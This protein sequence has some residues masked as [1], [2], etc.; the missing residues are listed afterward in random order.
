[1]NRIGVGE[2][3]GIVVDSDELA[4]GV[5]IVDANGLAN[6]ARF[7][8][9]L[10]AEAKGSGG[11]AYRV[12][13][14]FGEEDALDVT[15]RCTCPAAASRDFC[16]HATALLVAWARSPEAFAEGDEAPGAAR[17]RVRRGKATPQDLM[18]QGVEQ[19]VAL[20]RDLAVT[21][22]AAMGRDRVPVIEALGESLRTYK[23]R[24]LGARTLDLAK[25]LAEGVAQRGSM[26][27]IA[28][29]E[30]YCD[31]FLTA[32]K[33]EKHLAGG[34]P[35]DD[36]HVEE[37]VGKTWQKADRAPIA[38]LDLVEYAYLVK[39]TSDEFVIR[40]SR[41][42]DLVS[43]AHFSE[44]QIVP[45]F[46]TRRTDAK[47]SRA[48]AVRGG[49]RGSTY[50]GYPPTRLE[51]LDL[52]DP[53][54]I[55]HVALTPLVDVALTDVSAALVA[56]AEHRRDVF[57]PE[58]LP[59][60]VRVDTL[61]ARRGRLQAVDASGH[62]LHLP[63]D[64][65]LE[66][67][68]GDKLAGARLAALL[69]DVGVDAALPTLWPLAA[70]VERSAGYEL[71]TVFGQ[72]E[73]VRRVTLASGPTLGSAAWAETARAAGASDVTIALAEV[74]EALADAFA[75]GLVTL[76]PKVA[77]P[78]A[79]RL[80]DLGLEKQAELL[81]SI[82]ERGT[83]ARL[84]DFV[85]LFHVLGI[86]LVRLA[87]AA[88]V[89]RA[90]LVQVPTFESVFV[91]RPDRWLSPAEI[92]AA[93]AKGALDRYEAAVQAAHHYD[94]VPIE[95][96]STRIFPTWADG[97][98][99][100]YVARAFAKQPVEGIRAAKEAL[101]GPYGRVARMTGMRVLATVGGDEAR[102]ILD[103]LA[104][105]DPD[106][107]LRALAGLALD[108]LDR[109]TLGTEAVYRRRSPGRERVA[110]A[111]RDLASASTKD[112]RLAAVRLLAEIGDPSAV[113]ALRRAFTSDAAQEVRRDAAL[114]LALFVDTETVPV[115]VGQLARWRDSERD[116]KVAAAA[117]GKLGDVRGRDA[118][119]GARADG[120]APPVVRD[121]LAAL[122][123][124][125]IEP[126]S[127]R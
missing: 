6:L 38:G 67:W 107:G 78:L 25:L 98:A 66:A 93:R 7:K 75:V 1:M 83:E 59:V 72:T 97:S 84:E 118:L 114:T 80:S 47:P 28:Y 77:R 2:L 27:T 40:E 45:G 23:L 111:T 39:V 13:L 50:P 105:S 68:L 62:V 74:R 31:V 110:E 85:K 44:K 125:A 65:A 36:R 20:A 95:D 19:V 3:K 34:E 12:S 63:E 42:F 82:G 57:A 8:N 121:A 88:E 127:P 99:S 9:K 117:L 30:L 10:Y 33:L 32:R 49:V 26:S 15:A 106:A 41:L 11:D 103:D 112:Q 21:G 101:A 120:F 55:D 35:L 24:R 89:D 5:A 122:E 16:K 70:I 18:K 109:E 69:G 104:A 91:A 29:A 17:R 22:V 4:K 51:I 43:G 87:G 86:A 96:L 14:T 53:R 71:V 60:A 92:A 102:R 116:A 61:V 64:A 56:L 52:G 48:G 46:L 73:G 123:P 119:L 58:L 94:E 79:S 54:P 100:E 76:G 108:T 90:A 37:L 124:M 113:P 126:R 115:F 81:R